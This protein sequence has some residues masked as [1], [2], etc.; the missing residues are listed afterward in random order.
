MK[1]EELDRIKQDDVIE[2]SVGL[3]EDGSYIKTNGHYTS[4]AE[5]I[6]GAIEA[7]DNA[8]KQE[9]LDRIEQDEYLFGRLIKEG[10]QPNEAPNVAYD[11]ANGVLTLFTEN[12]KH[13]ITIKLNG[14]YGIFPY[15]E[16]KD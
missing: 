5:T 8:L 15:K 6:A 1:Q 10:E 14:D 3:G 13:N 16:N 12:P 4:D 2:G 7:L 11:C 9:E